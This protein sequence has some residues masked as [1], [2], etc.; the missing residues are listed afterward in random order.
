MLKLIVKNLKI[1]NILYFFTGILSASDARNARRNCCNKFSFYWQ[2]IL[3]KKSKM[4]KWKYI[5]NGKENKYGK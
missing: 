1:K 5:S 3:I 4:L 2:R